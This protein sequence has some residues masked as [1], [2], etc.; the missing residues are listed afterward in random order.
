MEVVKQMTIIFELYRLNVCFAVNIWAN[1][2]AL[3]VKHVSVEHNR[4]GCPLHLFSNS[5]C[6]LRFPIPPVL[7]TPLHSQRNLLHHTTL[8][9]IPPLDTLRT[10][11]RN[12]LLHYNTKQ[13]CTILC[14]TAQQ[15][16]IS[17]GTVLYGEGQSKS[18]NDIL[19]SHGLIAPGPLSATALNG[20][21][22]R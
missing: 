13:P 8:H 17:H 15:T 6:F 20:C 2:T 12:V 22:S 19:M 21:Q 5:N 18:S 9:F 3:L 1:D 16:S 10:P 11:P 7:W 14:N 4:G